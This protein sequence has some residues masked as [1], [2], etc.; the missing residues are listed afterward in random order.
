M[1]THQRGSLRGSQP[2]TLAPVIG[3][4]DLLRRT[5]PL[6]VASPG[7]RSAI[8]YTLEARS[9]EHAARQAQDQIAVPYEGRPEF[10]GWSSVESKATRFILQVDEHEIL[11]RSIASTKSTLFRGFE[12]YFGS[13]GPNGWR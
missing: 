13:C 8:V 10:Q 11:L 3:V 9:F 1:R 5:T 4:E 6:E 7:M 2:A 12:H